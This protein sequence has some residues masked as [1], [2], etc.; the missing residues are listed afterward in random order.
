MRMF[1]QGIPISALRSHDELRRTWG[2]KG[3]ERL[4]QM[5]NQL[6]RVLSFLTVDTVLL[7]SDDAD[8]GAVQKGLE[9]VLAR[10]GKTYPPIV[11]VDVPMIC[12]CEMLE[13][14]RMH[15]AKKILS[16]AKEAKKSP[17]NR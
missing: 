6:M 15:L 9:E 8:V 1:S 11:A 17:A 12:E 7:E 14:L 2:T 4:A 10:E 5:A 13:R 16:N 3:Q